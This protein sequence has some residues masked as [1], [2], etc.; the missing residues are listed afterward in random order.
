SRQF[1]GGTSLLQRA[2]GV[3]IRQD[4][5]LVRVKDFRRFGHEMDSAK[6]D[7]IGVRLLSLISKPEGVAHVISKV[8]NRP[9]LV[10]VSQNDGVAFLFKTEDVLFQIKSG[11]HGTTMR[12]NA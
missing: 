5:R 10:I 7:D 2:T 8:L 6:S 4:D 1:I 12:Q 9:D 3:A 11:L